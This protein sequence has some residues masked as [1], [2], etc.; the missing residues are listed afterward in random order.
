MKIPREA[1]KLARECFGMTLQDGKVDPEKVRHIA[2][3][4]LAHKPRHYFLILKELARHLRLEAQKH[5]ALVE[6]AY[7]LESDT[8]EQIQNDLISRFGADTT[9]SFQVQPTLIGGMRVKLG[10]DVWD[11]S[12]RSRLDA[13][14]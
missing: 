1:R 9:F 11:G 2:E 13:L 6:S 8:R 5:H 10:S 3:G 7:P 12:V 4:L 14:R